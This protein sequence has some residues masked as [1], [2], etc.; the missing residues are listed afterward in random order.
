[1]EQISVREPVRLGQF[2]KLTGVADDGALAKEMLADELISVNGDLETRRGRQLTD[3]DVVT[4]DLPTG[5][6]SFEVSSEDG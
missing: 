6:M 2:L 3:G 4:L 1:M 5:E